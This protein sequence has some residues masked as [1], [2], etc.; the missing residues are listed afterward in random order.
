[1]LRSFTILCFGLNCWCELGALGLLD[2]RGFD[3]LGLPLRARKRRR[4]DFQHVSVRLLSF[5]FTAYEVGHD[6]VQQRNGCANRRDLHIDATEGV[7]L[8][9]LNEPSSLDFLPEMLGINCEH[10]SG[11]VCSHFMTRLV[12][13][14]FSAAGVSQHSVL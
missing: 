3:R 8:Q 2:R 5:D 9:S 1:M 6:F 13:C 10:L 14:P 7:I 4:G 11:V 12:C